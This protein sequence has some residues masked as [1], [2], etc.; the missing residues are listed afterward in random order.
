MFSIALVQTKLISCNS[1]DKKGLLQVVHTKAI[2][3]LMQFCD[4]FKHDLQVKF[5]FILYLAFS[6]HEI[7]NIKKEHFQ[8]SS[9]PINYMNLLMHL[10]FT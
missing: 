5:F 7:C 10:N 8:I 3:A 4:F 6:G 9:Q 1:A 2:A